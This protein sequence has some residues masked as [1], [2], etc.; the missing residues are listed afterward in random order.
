MKIKKRFSSKKRYKNNTKK[1]YYGGEFIMKTKI[2][3]FVMTVFN[4]MNAIRD[5]NTLAGVKID[6]YVKLLNYLKIIENGNFFALSK[7]ELEKNEY[8]IFDVDIYYPVDGN[9]DNLYKGVLGSRTFLHFLINE[10]KETNEDCVHVVVEIINLI[11]SKG[12]DMNKQ[13]DSSTK[14]TVP[15]ASLISTTDIRINKALLENGVNIDIEF[16]FTMPGSKNNITIMDTITF[17]LANYKIY[18]TQINIFESNPP[19]DVGLVDKYKKGSDISLAKIKLFFNLRKENVSNYFDAVINLKMPELVQIL[20]DTKA[21]NDSDISKLLLKPVFSEEK[22]E[23]EFKILNNKYSG[24]ELLASRNRV[25]RDQKVYSDIKKILIA[26]LDLLSSK[27]QEDIVNS[28]INDA[29]EK[30]DVKKKKKKKKNTQIVTEQNIPIVIDKTPPNDQN[31]QNIPPNDQNIPP[32]V[33]DKTNEK[34]IEKKDIDITNKLI[35]DNQNLPKYDDPEKNDRSS[36][37]GFNLNTSAKEFVPT[38]IN[39][40][41]IVKD[42]NTYIQ[43]VFSNQDIESNNQA[44][45]DSKYRI[46]LIEIQKNFP[47]YE[48]K[49]GYESGTYKLE[50]A[51]ILLVIGFI[52]K[53]FIDK[54]LCKIILKGGKALQASRKYKSNDIDVFLVPINHNSVS[55]ENYFKYAEYISD[56]ILNIKENLFKN[57]KWYKEYKILG[58]PNNNYKTKIDSSCI[59][60]ISTDYNGIKKEMIDIGYGYNLTHKAIKNIIF[61]GELI[62]TNQMPD[63]IRYSYLSINQIM[64][65]KIYYYLY[66]SIYNTLLTANA[67]FINKT[68]EFFAILYVDKAP[69]VMQNDINN[70][71]ISI[72]N[73]YFSGYKLNVNLRYIIDTLIYAV[74]Q[75]IINR[76]FN[77]GGSNLN[78]IKSKEK[79]KK[80]QRKSKKNVI[81]KKRYSKKRKI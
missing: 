36:P 68:L 50:L 31:N 37:T 3:Q 29:D 7:D 45:I 77:R 41:K 21:L 62:E 74:H 57:I 38:G 27:S 28:L 24:I 51:V 18:Q 59:V 61:N 67:H 32:N 47:E 8:N 66:Y 54:K 15:I 17:W 30:K 71:C 63:N 42:F 16:K 25:K 48:L 4:L 52:Y 49:I 65:E 44:L 20:I 79:A 35:Q 23:M 39:I 22:Q 75:K 11:A 13:L 26:E 60:K 46:I 5:K 73:E 14:M 12:C 70:S 9:V 53:E 19:T 40:D 76:D 72:Y 78:T 34:Y 55:N 81:Q 69:D 56:I 6:Y 33:I 64:V 1:V 43:N 58:Q 2:D 10:V 80:K